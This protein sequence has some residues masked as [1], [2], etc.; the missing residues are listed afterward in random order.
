M[1]KCRRFSLQVRSRPILVTIGIVGAVLVLLAISLLIGSGQNPAQAPVLTNYTS[2][3]GSV[4]FGEIPA[5]AEIVYHRDG[6]VYVMDRNG[7][8][9]TRLTFEKSRNWEHV[10]VSFDHRYVVANEQLPNPSGEAGG[11]SRVWLFDLETGTEAQLVPEFLT[12]GNGGVDWDPDGF[13]YFAG[14]EKDL[15]ASPTTPADFIANAGANDVYKVR[16]DGT[17]LQRL[18][19]TPSR[20]EADVSVSEDG[21]LVAFGALVIEPPNDYSEIWVTNS[22]GSDPQLVYVGGKPGVSSVHDPEISPDNTKVVFSRVNS[23]VPPNFPDNPAANTAHDIYSVSMDGT[24]LARLTRPGPIS[25]IPD[26]RDDSILYLE[27]NDEGDY[28]G[29]SMVSANGIEQAPRR[30]GLGANVPK[31]IP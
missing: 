10:A 3:P 11:R 17:A 27:L 22:D 13:V 1:G 30:I 6:F 8:H 29:A 21:S 23:D 15:I 24:G 28:L 4:R 25:I 12:A 20:G 5:T 31:W 26:W 19:N 16:L 14:K 18:T 7:E 2:E 9:V